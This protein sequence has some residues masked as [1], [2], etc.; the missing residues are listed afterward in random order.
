MLFANVRSH[1]NISNKNISEISRLQREQKELREIRNAYDVQ[2]KLNDIA[3]LNFNVDVLV[4]SSHHNK[5]YPA[6]NTVIKALSDNYEIVIE[7]LA[8]KPLLD[9]RSSIHCWISDEVTDKPFKYIL[10]YI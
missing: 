9:L 6:P 3:K 5:Y 8:K 1:F 10:Y 4:I 2:E 7:E